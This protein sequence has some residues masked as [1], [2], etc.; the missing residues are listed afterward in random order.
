MPCHIQWPKCTISNGWATHATHLNR[1]FNRFPKH[2]IE[3]RF[4]MIVGEPWWTPHPGVKSGDPFI[5]LRHVPRGASD[6]LWIRFWPMPCLSIP[7]RQHNSQH[8][9]SIG[10]SKDVPW[11]VITFQSKLSYMYIYIYI[12]MSR[13]YIYIYIHIAYIELYIYIRIYGDASLYVPRSKMVHDIGY[14]R[15][16]PYGESWWPSPIFLEN[17]SPNSGPANPK[18]LLT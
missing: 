9:N 13:V 8:T 2:R 14:G 12:Y 18:H 7:I 5:S 1:M 17:P 10:L 15:S 6:P 4:K 11:F 16:I 3:P